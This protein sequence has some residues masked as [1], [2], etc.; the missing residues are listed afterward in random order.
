MAIG[1]PGLGGGARVARR[2]DAGDGENEEQ[3]Q[4]VVKWFDCNIGLGASEG[5]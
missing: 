1:G 5:A 2:L 3:S 4:F